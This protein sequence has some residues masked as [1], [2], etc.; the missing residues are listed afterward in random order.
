MISGISFFLGAG[1]RKYQKCFS[2]TEYSRS[3]E[4]IF[5]RGWGTV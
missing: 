3:G 1:T 2:K 4:K 5:S